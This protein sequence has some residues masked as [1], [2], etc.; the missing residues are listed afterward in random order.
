[1][2][3]W[4]W[5]GSFARRPLRS[6]IGAPQVLAIELDQIERAEHGGGIVPVSADQIEDGE[7]VLVADDG[8][9]VDQA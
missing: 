5:P 6:S 3:S 2:P 1:M 8:L 9:T 4:G 7:A